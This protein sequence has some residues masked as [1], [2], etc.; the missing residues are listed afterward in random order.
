MRGG[1][2]LIKC[3]VGLSQDKCVT[4]IKSDLK[5]ILCYSDPLDQVTLKNR[6]DQGKSLI[7]CMY[8]AIALVPG[9]Y[10]NISYDSFVKMSLGLG[11]KGFLP[12]HFTLEAST[13]REIIR[14]KST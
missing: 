9:N 2:G 13:T 6:K 1:L 8:I 12:M 10:L 3:A 4:L 11:V 5:D 14:Y 7:N